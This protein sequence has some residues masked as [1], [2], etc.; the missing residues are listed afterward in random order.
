MKKIK[1][2]KKIEDTTRGYRKSRKSRNLTRTLNLYHHTLN[3]VGN[4]GNQE[5]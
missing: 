3:H 4:Q 1:E 2:I 5:I